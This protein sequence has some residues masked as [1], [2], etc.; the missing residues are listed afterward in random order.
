MVR[1]ACKIERYHSQST[2]NPTPS[3]ANGIIE[4]ITLA[5]PTWKQETGMLAE[6][7][8]IQILRRHFPAR[9]GNSAAIC[10]GLPDKGILGSPGRDEK[11]WRS[12]PVQ[13]IPYRSSPPFWNRM[14]LRFTNIRNLIPIRRNGLSE[15]QGC[16]FA[17]SLHNPAY[18][19]FA[20]CIHGFGQMGVW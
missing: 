8:S 12:G 19:A 5:S 18:M 9:T 13:T 2:S 17:K 10:A 6:G 15:S 14:F 20:M 4:A 16:G 1:A 11:P 3:T 7:S